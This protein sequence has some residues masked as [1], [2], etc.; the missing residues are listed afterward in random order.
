M[1]ANLP[2]SHPQVIAAAH[3]AMIR[4]NLFPYMGVSE[5]SGNAHLGSTGGTK[6]RAAPTDTFCYRWRC[7][8]R[9]ERASA[10]PGLPRLHRLLA[11]QLFGA[12]PLQHVG[13]L[14]RA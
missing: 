1:G 11:R 5:C 13:A 14:L 12:R 6:F 3:A 4:A 2:F 7:G 10:L 8:C 9:R